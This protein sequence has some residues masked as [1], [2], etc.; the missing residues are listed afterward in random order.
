[1]QRVVLENEFIRVVIAPKYGAKIIE[2][3]D[4]RANYQWLWTDP[5]RKIRK[6]NFRDSYESHDISGFDDCFPNIG[7]SNYALDSKIELP[8]HGDLWTQSAS[9]H[10]DKTSCTTLIKGISFEY[11]FERTLTLREDS[12][13]FNYVVTNTGKSEFQGFW[14]AHPLFNAI[15]G[16][17]IELEGNPRMTKEFGFSNRMGADGDDGYLG[18]LDAYQWPLTRGANGDTHDLSVIALA[19][20]LTDK[21]VLNSPSDGRITLR[22]PKFDCS[23]IFKFDPKEIPY[24]GI[25]FNLNAWPFKGKPGCWL[26]I[27]PT[28]GATDKLL[29][30]RALDALLTFPAQS[31]VEFGFQINCRVG[32]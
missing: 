8:D 30:S 11:L 32:V 14:S 17:R 12:L 4:K 28:Q 23:L 15:D 16:M 7:I 31:K 19:E 2:I 3:W 26:A 25:C 18:H 22:N 20:I 6:R 10:A 5:S 1:M 9:W 21:V 13:E 27:E 29:E 24:A